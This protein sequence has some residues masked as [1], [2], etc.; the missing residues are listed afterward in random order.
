MADKPFTVDTTPKPRTYLEKIGDTSFDLVEAQLDIS[1]DVTLWHANPR[2]LPYLANEN[3]ASEEEIEAAIQTTAGYDTLRKSID[4]LGQLE[5]IYVWRPDEHSKYIVFEGATRVTILRDLKRKNMSG[6]KAGRF[7]LVRAKILPPHFTETERVILL[8]RIHVRGSG[9]R[10]WGRYVEAKFIYDN[11]EG[12]KAVM[13]ATQMATHMGKSLPWVTRLRD[14]YKFAQQFVTYLD[15]GVEAEKLAAQK[16]SVLEEISKAQ[17][18]GPWLRD[19]DNPAYD[20]LR[21]EVFEMVR[22]NVFKE[23]RDARF[24]KQFYDD[25]EKWAT[26]KAGDEHAATRLAAEVKHS[27]TSLKTKISSLEGAIE[28]ATQR[29]D[30]DLDDD[31]I[32][33]LRRAMGAIQQAIHGGAD[34]FR[35]ELKYVTLFLSGATMANIK[36]LPAAEREAFEEAVGFFNMLTEKYGAAA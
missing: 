5:P 14:A 9:V 21:E 10:S 34:S 36:A 30:H 11:V 27:A 28:R 18:I 33:H 8:A 19:Y 12:D 1:K 31:D 25:P 16:F 26:L 35:L 3:F 2:L 13:T 17:G 6:A 23:Y 24:L 15:D 4:Q 20:A 7:N 22:N 32:D 29:D